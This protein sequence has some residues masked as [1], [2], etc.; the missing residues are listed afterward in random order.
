MC[1]YDNRGVRISGEAKTVAMYYCTPEEKVITLEMRKKQ[2]E[3]LKTDLANT[4][5]KMIT[6]IYSIKYNGSL[7]STRMNL[8]FKMVLRFLRIRQIIRKR[9]LAIDLYQRYWMGDLLIAEN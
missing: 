5:S 3:K 6:E 1:C 2:I 8:P 4:L 7:C 9:N